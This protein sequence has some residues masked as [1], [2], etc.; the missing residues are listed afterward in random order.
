MIIK[1]TTL[2]QCLEYKSYV[3]LIIRIKARFIEL[4]PSVKYV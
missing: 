1:Y 2:E 4:F 3:R